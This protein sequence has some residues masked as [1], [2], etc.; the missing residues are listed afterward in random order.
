MQNIIFNLFVYHK[1]PIYVLLGE[2]RE[3]G[4]VVALRIQGLSVCEI[5]GE[6]SWMLRY[7]G[8]KTGD[9]RETEKN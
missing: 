7:E 2:Y 4:E 1:K 9:V 6:A 3:L 5:C 8:I